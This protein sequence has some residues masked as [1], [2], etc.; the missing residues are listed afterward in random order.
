MNI[1][2]VVTSPIGHTHSLP[3]P[4]GTITHRPIQRRNTS[5]FQRATWPD[6]PARFA[7]QAQAAQTLAKLDKRRKEKAPKAKRV[8]KPK[9]EPQSRR[10]PLDVERATALYLDGW[11]IVRIADEL[12]VG[13]DVVRSRL[14]EANVPMRHGKE[15]WRKHDPALIVELA[16]TMTRGQIAAHLG[17][18][19]RTVSNHLQDA[20]VRAVPAP[21]GSAAR[22]R[23][24]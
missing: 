4:V 23:A 8:R 3:T 15:G 13:K 2:G 9:P 16:K 22:K 6:D 18:T 5:P 21:R 14:N 24:S 20:G 7:A 10:T 17:I 1:Q 12:G 11:N 19:A